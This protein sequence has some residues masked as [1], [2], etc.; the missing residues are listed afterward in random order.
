MSPCS[1]R[2][3]RPAPST[4]RT[5]RPTGRI[6]HHHAPERSEIATTSGRTTGQVRLKVN[7]DEGDHEIKERKEKSYTEQG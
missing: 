3:H 1:Q 7:I 5:F 2:W 6:R 4:P